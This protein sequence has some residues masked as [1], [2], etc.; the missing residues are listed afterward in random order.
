M[1]DEE[2]EMLVEVHEQMGVLMRDLYGV[3]EGSPDDVRPLI[4]EMRTVVRAFQRASWVT[5]L[6]IWL[7]PTLAG[8]GVAIREITRWF[9]GRGS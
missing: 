4:Y 2:R 1:T 5:R 9:G 6:L 8:L 7:L 3:P